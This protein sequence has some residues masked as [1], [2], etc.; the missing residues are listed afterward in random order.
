MKTFKVYFRFNKKADS[1][2]VQALSANAVLE[3]LALRFPKATIATVVLIDGSK[4]A[5]VL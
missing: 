2:Y 4:K 1:A 3:K 5:Q